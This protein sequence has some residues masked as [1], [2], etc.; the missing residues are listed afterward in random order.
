MIEF[1]IKMIMLTT[2]WVIMWKIATAEGMILEELGKWGEK[3]VKEGYKIFDGLIVCQWCLAN[4]H[5][6]LFV[7]P[8]AF[9]MGIMPFE[10]RWEYVAAYPF[11]LG[12]S[13]MMSGFIWA[14]YTT[15]NAKK[16]YYEKM[17][18]KTHLDIKN[19]KQDYHNKKTKN[20]NS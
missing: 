4:F 15:L 10:F 16:E 19:L 7:W 14:W 2:I 11:C 5:G 8:L 17:E 18:E 3:K 13:S 1:I 6:I 20:G 12:G 9:I